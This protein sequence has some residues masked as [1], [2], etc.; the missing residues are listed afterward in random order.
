MELKKRKDFFGFALSAVII[1]ILI[2]I[3]AYHIPFHSDDYVFYL[4][5]RSLKALLN[6]Y[7]TWEGRLIGDYTAS[8]LIGSFS[9]PVYMAINSLIFFN[10][11]Y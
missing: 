2:Y 8:L 6:H 1:F 4:R 11:C 10:S 7:L 3:P 5:G 9:K